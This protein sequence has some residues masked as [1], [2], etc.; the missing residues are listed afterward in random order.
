MATKSP[1]DL[2]RGGDP[3]PLTAEE[4]FDEIEEDL[5]L[6]PGGT[7]TPYHEGDEEDPN[8]VWFGNPPSFTVAGIEFCVTDFKDFDSAAVPKKQKA[9]AKSRKR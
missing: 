6:L 4:E 3:E 8:S 2:K 5:F 9:Q 1:A 7:M